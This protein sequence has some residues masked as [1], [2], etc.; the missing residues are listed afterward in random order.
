MNYKLKKLIR[1][2][3]LK[4]FRIKTPQNSPNF[5][6]NYLKYKWVLMFL[7]FNFTFS[8]NSSKKFLLKIKQKKITIFYQTIVDVYDY[9][10]RY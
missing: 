9:M 10:I 5:A 2:R 8:R 7:K 4:N 3:K 6:Q 1:N